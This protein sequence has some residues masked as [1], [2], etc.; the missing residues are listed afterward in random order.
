VVAP[1][2]ATST[3]IRSLSFLARQKPGFSSR[4]THPFADIFGPFSS[5]FAFFFG[6]IVCDLPVTLGIGE[7]K[8]KWATL[9]DL[10]GLAES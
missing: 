10:D 2:F 6:A 1:W 8:T 9:C 5:F 3:T 7:Q 4:H